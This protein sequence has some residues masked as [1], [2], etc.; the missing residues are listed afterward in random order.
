VI[1][2]V[3]I[4][5][6]A[7]AVVRINGDGQVIARSTQAGATGAAAVDAIREIDGDSPKRIGA[8]VRDPSS[9][10]A[11][12][13]VAAAAGAAKVIAAPKVVTKGAAVA[14]AEQWLGAARGARHVVG[15]IATDCVDAGIVVDGHIF[16]GAH[17]LAGAAGWL[18]LNPVERDDYRRLGCLEAEIGGSGIVRRLVWRIKAGDPSRVHEMVNGQLADITVPHIFDAARQGDG[19]AIAVVRDTARYIGMAIGNLVA[20][21][22][23]EV[24]VLGGLIAEAADLLLEPSR[25][26]AGRRVSAQ[27]FETL[28]IVPGM[29]GDDA[30][31]I[32]AARAALLDRR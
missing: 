16:E 6:G 15:L 23:P 31:A 29:L 9:A 13:I 18:A 2:G 17:G 19:V 26:E 14:L 27:V 10:A 32:G 12:D 30:A 8:A 20:I 4:R 24:V 28:R 11:T 22:D 1:L 7:I 3:D 5:D 21:V 25:A